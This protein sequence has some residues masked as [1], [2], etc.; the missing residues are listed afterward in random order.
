M[1]FAIRLICLRSIERTPAPGVRNFIIFV[2]PSL[3][4]ITLYFVVPCPGVEK[5]NFTEMH[6]FYTFT[7][8]LFL[9]MG[10]M[11]FKISRLLPTDVICYIEL[12]YNSEDVY[13]NLSRLIKAENLD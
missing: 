11:K 9:G 7:P 12:A 2:D 8:K 5:K 6:Q 13:F 1:H 4:I 3:V 10:V